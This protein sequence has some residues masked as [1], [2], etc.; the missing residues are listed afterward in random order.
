MGFYGRSY[1]LADASEQ[2]K[3]N[4]PSDFIVLE[5]K[6]VVFVGSN[7]VRGS[8]KESRN[9]IQCKRPRRDSVL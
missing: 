2:P 3:I 7:V 8:L 9:E 4:T 5:S 1:V 6:V